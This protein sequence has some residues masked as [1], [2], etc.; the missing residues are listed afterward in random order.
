MDESRNRFLHEEDVAISIGLRRKK[1][2]KTL[3]VYFP[4][5]SIKKRVL[6][7]QLFEFSIHSESPFYHFI[8]TSFQLASF[9]TEQ[10]ASLHLDSDTL[11]S[12][13]KSFPSDKQYAECDIV[14]CVFNN[15][16]EPI[17]SVEEAFMKLQLISQRLIRPHQLCLDGL[18]SVLHNLA[19]TNYGP[20]L[21]EDIEKERMKRLFTENPLIV[22]YVDKIP[23][24]LHYHVPS[25]VRIASGSQVR[26]GAYLGEGTT[27]MPAGYIN[28]NAGTEGNAMVEGRVSAGVM[29]QKDTDI[30]GGASIMGT[31]SGGNNHVISV[32]SNCLLGANSGLGISLGYGCTVAAG[33]YIYAGMKIALFNADNQ[34]VNLD[35]EVVQNG[36]NIVK[37]SV[38]SGKDNLLFIQDS[39]TGVVMCKPNPKTI[40]LNT[41]LHQN[42]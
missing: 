22:S 13:V 40:V 38:L 28:F 17:V 25:G 1:K 11:S 4:S 30:G 16:Q 34:A 33:L 29:V 5:I 2:G 35:G 19:W 39:R 21:L 20:I 36:E 3:D 31:L 10:M 23:Y 7:E 8:I 37:A 26:L 15:L 32:G 42:D 9:N 41:V 12:L 14:I 24:L 18:F 27:V 6:I